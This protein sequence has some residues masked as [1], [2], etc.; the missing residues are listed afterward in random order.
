MRGSKRPDTDRKAL[1][2]VA[3]PCLIA[4]LSLITTPT[5]AGDPEPTRISPQQFRQPLEMA[6]DK[7]VRL[8]DGFDRGGDKA[9]STVTQITGLEFGTIRD[10]V[11]YIVVGIDGSLQT[12]SNQLFVGGTT[13]AAEIY[14]TGDPN[15]DASVSVS[16]PISNGL[17]LTLFTTNHGMLPTT[18]QLDGSGEGTLMIGARLTVDPGNAEPGA[19]QTIDYTLSVIT[20]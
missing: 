11:G 9:I 18:F 4:A 7:V 15:S 6:S 14:I 3:A 20:P 13:Q 16:A 2:I 8:S 1:R 19:G 10:R 17:A 12:D 5:E